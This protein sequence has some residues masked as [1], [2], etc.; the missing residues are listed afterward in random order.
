MSVV[1]KLRYVRLGVADPR[2]TGDFATRILGLQEVTSPEGVAMYRSDNRHASLI[3]EAAEA[4]TEAL[5]VQVRDPED[6]EAMCVR[7]E[8]AGYT[9]TAGTA[10]ECAARLCKQMAWIRLRNGPRIEVV[11][12]PLDSG[13]RYHGTRDAGIVEFFGVAFAS[14]DVAADTKLWTDVFGG[15]VADYLGDAV[16]IAI[17]D[18]HHRIAIH[19]SGR[20]AI[21]EVQYEVEG[22]HQLMQNNYFLQSAQVPI[23]AGPGRRPTS[24]EAF[25]TFRGP[26]AVLFGYVTEGARR[27]FTADCPPRQFPHSSEGLCAWGSTSTVPEYSA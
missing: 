5:A 21:L 4:P 17:D 10:A 13:W 9:V 1:E 16:Y 19:P 6:L 12:R 22:L 24:D 15:K 8:T 2:K 14:T 11:V 23:C 3:V 25:L 20:D 7:L 27:D 26:D 18:A